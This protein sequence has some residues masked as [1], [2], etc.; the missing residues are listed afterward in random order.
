MTNS[1][2]RSYSFLSNIRNK[3]RVVTLIISVQHSTDSLSQNNWKEREIE[4]SQIRKE[5]VKLPLFADNQIFDIENSGHYQNSFRINKKY[6]QSLGY[7]S[8]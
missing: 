8:M 5:E 1:Q 6:Q 7:K 4:V 2:L 3:S